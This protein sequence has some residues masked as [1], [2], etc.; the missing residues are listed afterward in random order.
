MSALRVCGTI[1]AVLAGGSLFA[2]DH[3]DAQWIWYDT[4]NP[5]QSAP[6]GKV[7]FRREVRADD[8]STGAARVIC[9][10]AENRGSNAGLFVDGE[11]R[12]Q[13]GHKL[14]FD[15]GADWVATTTAPEGTAW[16]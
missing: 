12:S 6:A 16:L 9:V 2:D 15:T 3:F 13:G 7:W 8:P 4:G 11:V 14:P 5:T 10:E 1:L